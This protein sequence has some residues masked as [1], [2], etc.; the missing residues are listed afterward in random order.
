MRT[1]IFD[2]IAVASEQPQQQ[3]PQQDIVAG[4]VPSGGA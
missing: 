4:H 2:R 1:S 3:M